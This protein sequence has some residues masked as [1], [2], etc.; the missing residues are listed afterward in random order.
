MNKADL[1]NIIKFSELHDKGIL[2]DE[3][4]NGQKKKILDSWSSSTDFTLEEELEKLSELHTRGILTDEE[5]SA[6]KKNV[7]N[8]NDE[9]KK[10]SEFSSFTT[11]SSSNSNEKSN[12]NAD[13]L[14]Y[15][16]N[17]QHYF[18]LE[19][20][21]VLKN[22]IKDESKETIERIRLLNFRDS[23]TVFIV[24]IFA[25]WLGVDRFMLKGGVNIACGIAKLVLSLLCVGFIWWI[26]D[27]FFIKS[28][29]SKSNMQLVQ[30]CLKFNKM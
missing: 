6:Q 28:L 1:E 19:D 13:D 4:Y 25:G 29:T 20:S 18:T 14:Y 9:E 24:S 21:R 3:E 15:I 23:N 12:S 2:T 10:E 16:I 11:S 8:R 5:F 7:L 22:L 17:N 26:I 27:F 30:E